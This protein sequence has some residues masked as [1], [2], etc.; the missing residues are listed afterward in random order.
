M[1]L[2]G[3]KSLFEFL[4]DF[5]VETIKPIIRTFLETTLNT[6][7]TDES[8]TVREEATELGEML[9]GFDWVYCIYDARVGYF[10]FCYGLHY[11]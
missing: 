1:I 5:E 6:L 8:V 11:L 9:E 3:C 10:M 2:T 4:V 7:S